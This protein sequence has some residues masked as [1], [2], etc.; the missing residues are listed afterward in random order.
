MIGKVGEIDDFQS[1]ITTPSCTVTGTICNLLHSC[2]S[3]I[4]DVGVLKDRRDVM[5][6]RYDAAG[7]LFLS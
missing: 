3:F 5:A 7:C 2:R 1:E 4:Y 6:L